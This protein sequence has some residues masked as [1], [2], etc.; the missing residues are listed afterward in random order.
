MSDEHQ[1]LDNDEV[2][3][4]KTDNED[5]QE[6]ADEAEAEAQKNPLLMS[7]H[8]LPHTSDELKKKTSIVPAPLWMITFADI[9]AIMLTFFVLLY[10]MSVIQ[11]EAW[12]NINSSL[13]RGLSKGISVAKGPKWYA[14]E[15]DTLSIDKLNFSKAL[16]LGYLQGLVE[17]SLQNNED[18]QG[19]VIIPNDD[20]LILSLPS[21]VLFE[22]GQS[23]M[24]LSGKKALFALGG[25]LEHIRNRIEVIG[26]SD[27]RPVGE[28]ESFASNW[29]L[30]LS[31]ANSVAAIL[32]QVG[33]TRPVIVRGL[34]SARYDE[35]P[36]ALPEQE[37]LNLS[38]RVDLVIMKD[39]GR[40][41]V[42]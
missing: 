30:S 22:A 14:G 7:A 1:P 16:D 40:H 17:T 20:R 39:D 21:D 33:Y 42:F 36:D 35:L 25:T 5:E 11:E 38:R 9:M 3:I 29:E 13:T 8:P 19:L 24:S 27:P 32:E 41:K 6:D 34:S 4:F 15:Q 2:S 10:S 26:H 28:N 37:R 18:L 31:R 12:E 23:E